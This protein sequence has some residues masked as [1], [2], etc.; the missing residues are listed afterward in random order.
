MT[1]RLGMLALIA[2]VA[3]CGLAFPRRS[4]AQSLVLDPPSASL[5]TIPATSSEI[6]RPSAPPPAPVQVVGLTN[7][8]LGLL[9]ADVIDALFY[10]DDPIPGPPGT[11]VYFSVS[12]GPMGPGPAAVP[13]VQGES[14]FFLPPLTQDEAASD[15]F[16]TNDLA[17]LGFGV[18]TQIL[19]GNGALLGPASVCGYGGGAPFGLGLTELLP[20]P[21]VTFN[22][23]INAFDW[24]APGRGRL[25][26]IALSLAP[27]SPTLVPGG[28]PLLLPP[29]GAEPGD[30]LISCPGPAT[31][32]SPGL[33]VGPTAAGFGLVSGGPGCA[34]PACDDIDALGGGFTF[35]LSPTSPS[36]VGPPFFSAADLIGPGPA[37]VLPA[38]ALGLLPTDNVN[39]LES[40]INPCPVFAGADPPDFDG[41]APG[42]GCDNCPGVFNPGQEDT[43]GDLVGDACDPCTDTDGDGFGNPDFPANLCPVDLCPFTPSLNG[44][45]DGDGVGDEC[46][47]CPLIANTNQAD[48]DFDTAGDVCDNCPIDFNFGQADGDGDGIGDVC[49]ICTSGFGMTKAQLKIGKLL[50]PPGDEQLQAKGNISFPGLTLPIPPL[51]VINPAKGMRLQLVDIGAGSTVLFDYVVPGGPVPQCG[52]KDGWKTN[53]GLTAQKY[54]NKTNMNQN[55]ACAAGT[56]LGING[57]QAK[58]KTAKLKG[59]QFQVKGKNGT[60]G[61]VTGPFRMTVVLGGPGE[62]AGGQCGHHTFPAPNCVVSGGGKMLKCKQ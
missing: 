44:D 43:D 4:R 24:G 28:N 55:F 13:D 11:T 8:Q 49:D 37:I 61:P 48:G 46:D 19:D 9:P 30:I 10:F 3:L 32:S 15:L 23:N 35:S 62:S 47:N 58:D 21:P 51:D 6:L 50:A 42:P 56:A 20:T 29:F 16:V 17:C 34:P 31:Y 60:Y 41:V 52:P 18:H 27:G 26:C 57:A 5:G 2:L 59:A 36:V 40:S 33:F 53:P 45:A 54:G 22:D 12:R 7:A 1:R 14:A 38:G 39:A 25:F